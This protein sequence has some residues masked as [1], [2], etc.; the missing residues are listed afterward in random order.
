M[1]PKPSAKAKPKAQG[2]KPTKRK[3]S[4]P[5]GAAGKR[6]AADDA[7]ETIEG[8]DDLLGIID[9][10]GGDDRRGDAESDP[11]LLAIIAWMPGGLVQ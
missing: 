3:A 8:G 10:L 2:K 6:R 9:G 11:Q 5:G 7:T 4:E 1:P